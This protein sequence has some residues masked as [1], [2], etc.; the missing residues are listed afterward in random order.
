MSIESHQ[1]GNRV[2]G[3]ADSIDSVLITVEDSGARTWEPRPAYIPRG[4]PPQARRM[5]PPVEPSADQPP[6]NT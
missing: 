6:A 1:P 3:F 2:E 5:P 4:W